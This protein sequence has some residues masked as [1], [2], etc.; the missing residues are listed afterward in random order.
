MS[1]NPRLDED[2]LEG[3]IYDRRLFSRLLEFGKPYS[4]LIAGSVLLI[5]IGMGL[6]IL[7][8]YLTKVAI[9]R[10]ILPGHFRGLILIVSIYFG[11]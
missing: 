8:P 10:Y 4:H 2:K 1:T 6:E 11:V 7:G 5:I 9:D 3:K